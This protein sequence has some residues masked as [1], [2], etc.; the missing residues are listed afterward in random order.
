[1]PQKVIKTEALTCSMKGLDKPN[2]THY[3]TDDRD[4]I[5]GTMRWH[6]DYATCPTS[7]AGLATLS[8]DDP[9]NRIVLT[10]SKS[11]RLYVHAG[12]ST[13]EVRL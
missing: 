6:H 13:R 4:S 1:M 2:S 8:H 12:D 9:A 5:E 3:A 7:R 10:D 11:L